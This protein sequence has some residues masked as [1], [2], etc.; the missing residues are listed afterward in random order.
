MYYSR[1]VHVCH[2]LLSRECHISACHCISEGQHTTRCDVGTIV[3]YLAFL[4]LSS[5]LVDSIPVRALLLS[6]ILHLKF[7]AYAIWK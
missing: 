6:A 2:P 7:A 5:P 4:R 3:N 1:A